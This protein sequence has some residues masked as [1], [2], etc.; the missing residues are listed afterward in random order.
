ML[1]FKQRLKKIILMPLY[2]LPIKKK[3]IS[4][5]CYNCTQYS[6]N[7][8][9]ITTGMLEKIIYPTGGCVR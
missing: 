9:Y 7:P 6:C 4:F 2:F 1:T 3:R 5:I 8:K